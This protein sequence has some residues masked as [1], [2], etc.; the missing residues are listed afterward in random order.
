MIKWQAHDFDASLNNP[1][2]TVQHKKVDEK[3]LAQA[4]AD[5]QAAKKDAGV[6]GATAVA[7]GEKVVD[8][9]TRKAQ[10]KREHA[11]E[12]DNETHVGFF[13]I[14]EK[15]RAWLASHFGQHAADKAAHFNKLSSAEQ[16]REFEHA[17]FGYAPYAIFALMP[18]FALYL[19]LLY[20]GSGRMYGEH[21]LFA[22]HT[23]AFAFLV[24]ILLM[25][26]P[27]WIPFSHAALWLWLTFYLPT[28]MRKV[29]G[30]SRLATWT[31]WIVLMTLHL[32]S[33]VAAI[34]GAL[35]LA[36]IA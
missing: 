24:F 34:I 18:V 7:A 15:D 6:A 17:L 28:A 22:L 20:L 23:N 4:K 11:G 25:L 14:D 32:V 8:K 29:Y 10:E 36:V 33:M 19:K 2:V 27:G 26:V 3:D 1:T 16:L 21:L 5:L 31:R 30:G 12:G 9:L 35:A 13:D